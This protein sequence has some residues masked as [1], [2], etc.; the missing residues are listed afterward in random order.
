MGLGHLNSNNQLWYTNGLSEIRLYKHQQ[1]PDNFYPG[2]TYSSNKNKK[3]YNNGIIDKCFSYH[4]GEGWSLGRLHNKGAFKLGHPSHN[5]RKT[6]SKSHLFGL[7]WYHN[8]I[9][10]IRSK[11]HPGEGWIEGR[12]DLTIIK[13]QEED[14]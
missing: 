6:G 11:T 10:S 4:P 1:I 3:Y 14:L 12:C 7:K 5:K 2:R 9:K 13:Y 8:G